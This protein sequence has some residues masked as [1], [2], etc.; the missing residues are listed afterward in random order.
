M[1]QRLLRNFVY[2]NPAS[3]AA[4]A[5]AWGFTSG[6]RG[7]PLIQTR[8]VR[9]RLWVIDIEVLTFTVMTTGGKIAVRLL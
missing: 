4:S 3:L 7:M 6:R 8:I 2:S 5:L 9:S 1:C